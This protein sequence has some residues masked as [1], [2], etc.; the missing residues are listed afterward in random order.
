MTETEK[1][2]T[3][4][5]AIN[6][7]TIT[8]DEW[9]KIT[10][11]YKTAGGDYETWNNWNS[12]DP[13]RY[14]E[15]NNRSRWNS[16]DTSGGVTE[17]TLYHFAGLHGWTPPQDV[18][19]TPRR[20]NTAQKGLKTQNTAAKEQP[21]YAQIAKIRAYIDEKRWQQGAIMKYCKGR[22]LTAETI[23]RFKLGYDARTKRLVIPYPG[24]DYYTAR[25]LTPAQTADPDNPNA[26]KYRKPGGITAQIFNAPALTGGAEIVFIAEGEIDAIS[27]EQYG[28]AAIGSNEPGVVLNAIATAGDKLTA[29][30]FL[31]VPDNDKTETGEPDPTKGED[32]A[33]KMHEALTAAGVEA[34]IYRLPEQFHDANDMATQAG[35]DLWEWV[36]QGGVFAE[37][38]A[39]AAAD[40]YRGNTSALAK[41][42]ELEAVIQS[43]ATREAIRTGYPTL[44]NC[45]G[46]A[47]YPGGLY[48]GLY[49][50]GAISSLGKTTFSLQMADQIAATG[51]DVL[52]FSL[53]MATA[54]LMAKSISRLTYFTAADERHRKSTRG[55][56]SGARYPK[57][58]EDDMAA[59][60]QAKSRYK[61]L[62]E[63]LYIT[64][65]L[66]D[67]GTA[68]I[69]EA[70]R[71]HKALTG[72][73]PVVI[74]DYLQILAPED[75][76]ATDKQNT[77]R[78]VVELKRISRDYDIPVIAISSLNRDNY[79]GEITLSAFKE[80]GAIEY[81]GDVLFG[82]QFKGCKDKEFD[83]EAAKDEDPRHIQLKI[84]KNRNGAIP[85]YPIEFNYYAMVNYF[86]DVNS[87][88]IIDPR[89][90]PGKLGKRV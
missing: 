17:A 78:A 61:E 58:T 74:V 79:K 71:K 89:H 15:S 39:R 2:Q 34:Y 73:S 54:E 21:T 9:L 23:D 44:D 57:Y 28:G 6:P 36:E 81:S 56:L 43:N 60:T 5:M 8:G 63:H 11:A 83:F 48:P 29:R 68:E 84:L 37:T 47:G 31:I 72:Q 20:A 50:I 76:K 13:E 14:K 66:G 24:A 32:I 42:A 19:Y 88:A 46:D 26:P 77:D 4:L 59:I 51:Q 12:Q 62:A 70:V 86:E 16:I 41:L 53:E 87:G 7:Q 80:S 35:A 22:G 49:F 69:R 45:L 33:R 10:M 75:T 64:E 67:I 25:L 55:I 38:Q 30:K 1:A 40:E 65:A 82:L 18:E 85:K 27:L 3:A 90:G 52:I